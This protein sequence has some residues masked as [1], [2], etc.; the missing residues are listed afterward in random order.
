MIAERLRTA[1]GVRID[2]PAAQHIAGLWRRLPGGHQA[3]CH[4]P[5]YGLRFLVDGRVVCRASVC[6]RCNNV[7]GEAGGQPIHYE[8]DSADPAAQELLMELRRW[9]KQGGP[10][11]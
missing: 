10:G 11:A 6:W 1:P 3:R 4:Q 7:A 9:S 8:F 5:P 2:G